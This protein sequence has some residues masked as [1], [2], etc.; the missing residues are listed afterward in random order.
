MQ[1]AKDFL[2][3]SDDVYA[4]VADLSSDS[5]AQATAFKNWSIED[6]IQHLHFWNEA[7]LLSLT[8][9]AGFEAFFKPVGEHIFSG[10]DLKLYERQHFASVTGFELIESWR[11]LYQKTAEAF[12]T[13]DPSQRVAWVGPSMSARSSIT[14][15]QMET[16]SHAQAIYDVLGVDRVDTDRIRNIVVLG[17]NTYGWTFVNRK[18]DVP[19]PMPY[20]SL[21]APSGDVW[22][23]GDPQED[24]CIQGS[25]V[26]FAQVV[27]Q[28]RNV[29][30]TDLQVV[31]D[32]ANLWMANAQCF[33]GAPNP[34]PEP[35]VRFK[36]EV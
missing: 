20:V 11:G 1:Q 3:E 31:G 35:G 32:S 5:F 15:R 29:V 13:A 6:I 22:N 8:D 17:I 23:Y 12:A 25:A 24:N 27:T 36:A 7:A 16:W 10:K 19:D 21:T 26:A 9:A 33:A 30:D 14:A 4:L 28:T 18:L 34:V 2:A